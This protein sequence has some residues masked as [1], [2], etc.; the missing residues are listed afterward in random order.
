MRS[1]KH[2]IKREQSHTRMSFVE[3]ENQRSLAEGESN[4]RATL[5][6]MK[7]SFHLIL[8]LVVML[9]MAQGAWAGTTIETRTV[10]YYLNG[11][12]SGSTT[13][14]DDWTLVSG[15]IRLHYNNNAPSD[16]TIRLDTESNQ[17]NLGKKILRCNG[18]FEFPNLEGTVKSVAF[19]NFIL[20]YTILRSCTLR[21]TPQTMTSR[22]TLILAFIL[23]PL[24]AVR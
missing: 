17:T 21:G 6:H 24:R 18:F 3:C 11:G 9:T 13:Q 22:G 20:A 10:T 8:T 7:L 5:K 14:Q 16:N 19:T 1:M 2:S 15:G 23:Q 4:V 12:T